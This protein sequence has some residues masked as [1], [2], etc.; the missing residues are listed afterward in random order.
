MPTSAAASQPARLAGLIFWLLPA[1]AA[2]EDPVLARYHGGELRASELRGEAGEAAICAAAYREIYGRLARDRKLDQDEALAAELE[3]KRRRMAADLYRQ[4]RQPGFESRVT[5]AEIE[6][7]W[8]RRSAPGGEFHWPGQVDM[9]VLYLRCGVLPAERQACLERARQIDKRLARG[10]AFVD[11]VGEEREKSG[12]AN[13]TYSGTPLDKLGA[14]LRQ[15]AQ[16]TTPQS[17]SPWLEA[18]HGLFRIA[19]WG[20]RGAGARPLVQ[21]EQQLRRELGEKAWR[22]YEENQR[23]RSEARDRGFDDYLAAAAELSGDARQPA[24]V[25]AFEAEKERLLAARAY[26]GDR[27]SRP[28]DELLEKERQARAGELEELVLLVFAFPFGEPRAAYAKAGEIAQAL[29]AGAAD[30]PA[31]LAALPSRFPEL[32]IEQVGP[33]RHRA[34]ENALPEFAKAIEGAPAGSWRGPIKLAREGLWHLVHPAEEAPPPRGRSLAFVA[35]LQRAVPPLA[36]LRQELLQP[37]VAEL[38]A[39]GPYCHELLGRRFGLEILP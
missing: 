22:A 23:R 26:V 25:A 6:A 14:E 24:L 27:A 36:Q 18:P 8:K 11:L 20:Q 2:A 34:I 4:R 19:V 38:E 33:L 31:A 5:Q 37:H 15:L 13:G 32:R 10:T 3:A 12:N 16:S 9:D 7:E 29:T 39:G 28:K 35:V 1:A 17:L 30:L 21:V